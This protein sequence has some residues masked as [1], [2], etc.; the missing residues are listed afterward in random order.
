MEKIK[1]CVPFINDS[2]YIDS[3]SEMADHCAPDRCIYE[4]YG[5][6]PKD[7]IGNLRPPESVRPMTMEQLADNVK[8]LHAH[9]IR[10]NYIIN[11]ELIPIPLTAEY[12]NE[13]MDFLQQLTAAGVDE[14]TVTIPYLMMLIRKHFPNLKVNASICNE[15]STVSE[16]VEFEELGAEVL[17]LDRDVNRDFPLLRDI[18]RH[19]KGEIKVLCNSACVL[20]CIN[21][22]FHGTYSSAM[23]NSHIAPA[24]QRETAFPVPYC[25]FYCR[26][27]FFRDLT[28]LIKL[29]WIRPED[30]PVYA[31][32]GISLFKIDGRDKE[33]AY[34]LSVVGAYLE[35]SYP[36]NLFHLLQPEFCEQLSDIDANAE[37]SDQPLNEQE[38]TAL[39]DAFIHESR[40]WQVGIDNQAL[41]GF[42]QCFADEKVVCH[43]DCGACGYCS[44]YAEK[45]LINPQWRQEML[46]MLD[47]NIQT[48]L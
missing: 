46:Q 32:E 13:V 16:A 20:H 23:S 39:T 41:D 2:H 6:L 28:E 36:H 10:F 17:V 3:I 43:G 12:R 19:T 18:R 5:S 29:H 9:G 14:I 30:M 25:S 40:A 48:Q 42:L 4:L 45:I 38:L 24:A 31:N 11:S 33:P 8:K 1:L 21:V 37:V 47:Y 34:L 35:G 26:H 15:I 27:R 44:A 22:H 7:P